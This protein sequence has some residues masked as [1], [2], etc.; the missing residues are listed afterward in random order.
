MAE[1]AKIAVVFL[2]AFFPVVIATYQGVKNVARHLT[3]VGR[4]VR[5]SER[6]LWI[7]IVLPAA[8]PFVVT[9]LRLVQ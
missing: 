7:H 1:A 4:A 3:E 5:C 9:G 6:Q 2:F 8:V